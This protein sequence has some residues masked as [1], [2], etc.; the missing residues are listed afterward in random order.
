MLY[1]IKKLIRYYP[2]EAIK[3]FTSD[4]G[5]E[6]ACCKEVKDMG[7]SFYFAD[8]H[9]AWQRGTN[10]NSNR[11]LREFYPKTNISK[12]ELKKVLNI[13]KS[14]LENVQIMQQVVRN[15]YTN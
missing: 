9:S 4:Q 14:E 15:F 12:S 1:A 3:S 7:I 8:A 5:R 11:L 10:E 2:K 13:I 6:F